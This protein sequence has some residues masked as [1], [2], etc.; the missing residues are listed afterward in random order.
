[1][2]KL[3]TRSVHPRSLEISP[4]AWTGPLAILA[5]R[6]SASAT[7]EFITWLKDNGRA[8]IAGER[9][10]GAG[11]GYIDGGSAIPL[12]AARLHI[13]MPNC[14][15]YTGEGINEIEGIAPD[16]PIDWSITT[17]TEMPVL[18]ARPFERR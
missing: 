2:T 11:C 9:T 3:R 4:G 13:M 10:F 18:L 1:M 15:R 16:V 6:R 12:N 7:E 5:D 8:V 17:A 14:S